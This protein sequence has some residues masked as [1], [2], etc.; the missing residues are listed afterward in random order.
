MVSGKDSTRDWEQGAVTGMWL[1]LGLELRV[2]VCAAAE[3]VAVC[4]DVTFVASQAIFM[5]LSKTV[6]CPL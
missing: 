4:L 3:S 6:V 2:C 5:A 1:G